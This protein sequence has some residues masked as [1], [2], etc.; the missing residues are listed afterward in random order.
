MDVIEKLNEGDIF[1]WHYSDPKTNFGAWGDHHCCSRIAVVQDGVLRD[2]YWLHWSQDQGKWL[3]TGSGRTFGLNDLSR[4]KLAFV[5]NHADL[6]P[7]KEYD[8]NYYDDAD[9]VD[10]NHSNDTRGNF[11]LRK[12]AVRSQAKMLSAAR[13]K[14]ERSESDKR[15]A[16]WRSERLRESIAK[17]EAGDVSGFF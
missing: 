4:L 5:A 10:L 2:T 12:G 1:R 17:I 14:L 16:E 13:A 7:A 9:I 3:G 11:Y 6:V 15:D 8:A